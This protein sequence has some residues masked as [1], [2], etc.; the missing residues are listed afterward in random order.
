MLKTKRGKQKVLADK[1]K[2]AVKVLMTWDI[3]R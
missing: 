1:E 2:M 3:A